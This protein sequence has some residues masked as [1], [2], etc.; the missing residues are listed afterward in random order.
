MLIIFSVTQET[1][2]CARGVSHELCVINIASAFFFYKKK[3]SCLRGHDYYSV[4][5]L[6]FNFSYDT[7]EPMRFD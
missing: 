5:W 6:I 7:S 2:S 3:G 4:V 1:Q